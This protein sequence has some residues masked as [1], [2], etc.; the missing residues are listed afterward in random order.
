MFS[1]LL[2]E[3]LNPLSKH[4]LPI[5]KYLFSRECYVQYRFLYLVLT[6]PKLTVY[7]FI[8]SFTISLFLKTSVFQ[9]CSCTFYFLI[10]VIFLFSCIILSSLALYISFWCS[11]FLFS[12][13]Y[14]IFFLSFGICLCIKH[15]F[16]FTFLAVSVKLNY[17]RRKSETFSK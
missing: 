6:R 16:F 11:Q 12:S 17:Q 3:K 10:F 9:D 7:S 4:L 15:S 14:L 1:Q 2:Y 13:F 8:H 5:I